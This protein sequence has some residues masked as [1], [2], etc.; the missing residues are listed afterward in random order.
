MDANRMDTLRDTDGKSI[1]DDSRN[2]ATIEG[3]E[4]K[5]VNKYG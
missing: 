2:E 5:P 3:F 4:I 1:Q